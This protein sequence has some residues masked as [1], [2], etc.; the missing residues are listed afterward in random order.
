MRATSRHQS[1]PGV[2]HKEKGG[3]FPLTELIIENEKGAQAMG[4]PIGRYL[5]LAFPPLFSL[6]DDEEKKAI[7]LLGECLSLLL[8]KEGSVLVVGLGNR[9]LT[10]DA[11]GARVVESLVPSYCDRKL[12]CIAPGVGEQSGLASADYVKALVDAVSPACVL[13][14]D[15]LVARGRERLACTIQLTDTGIVPGSGICRNKSGLTPLVLGVPVI[16]VG[17]PTMMH[18]GGALLELL[19]TAADALPSELFD[20]LNARREYILPDGIE[21]ALENAVH[22]I[23]RAILSLPACSNWQGR[24][25]E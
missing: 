10:A 18:L 19:G 24:G 12:F 21:L 11:I 16:S 13:A 7:H 23:S 4:R 15:A 22:L 1:M 8:P 6:T 3:L 5:T 9:H 20:A 25:I 14:I 2:R 17:V